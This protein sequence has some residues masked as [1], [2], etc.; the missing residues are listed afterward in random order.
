MSKHKLHLIC[1]V[2][3]LSLALILS[4]CGGGEEEVAEGASYAAATAEDVTAALA[5]GSAIVVDARGTASYMGWADGGNTV[6]GHI[7]GATDFAANWLTCTYDDENNLDGMTRDQ[8]LQMSMENKGISAE[9]PVIIYDENGADATAVADY[10][11]AQGITDVKL[12][13]L[14]DWSGETA[15]Y[16]NYQLWAPPSA[17]QALINGETVTEL[18]A[19]ADPII[20]EVSWGTEEQSSYPAGHVPGAIHVNSDDFDDENNVYML[21]PDESLLELAL[22]LGVSADSSVIVTGDPIF[23]CRYAVI[24]EY[25]G[26]QNVCVMSGNW[27]DAGYELETT[28]NAAT[29]ITDFGADA[30]ADPDIIDTVAETEAMLGQD[31]YTLV[32]NRTREEYL[33]ETSGYSYFE[34]AGRIEGAVFGYAGIGNSSSMAYYR[35]V[36]GTMRNAAEILAMW[37]ECGIDTNNHLAFM[38]GGGYR[39]A[40][41]LWDARVLGLEDTSLYADGWCG[42]SLAGLPSVTGE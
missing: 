37:E 12:F 17:V 33:G 36:D 7:D 16:E 13:A 31:G 19:F 39:A 8:Y 18:A 6:G 20:L 1:I 10:F 21:D 40:E 27:V 9:T 34:Q 2:M 26:V 24:L 25:L 38:C 5:D 41:V 28:S 22:S 42:W 11:A 23:S 29:P 35:N 3:L 14:A 32:D 30:P 4:A 15:T